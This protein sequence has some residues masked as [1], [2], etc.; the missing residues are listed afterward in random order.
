MTVQICSLPPEEAVV[1]RYIE[2]LWLPFHRELESTVNDHALATGVDLKA[3][4]LPFRLEQLEAD[5]HRA[6]VAVERDDSGPSDASLDLAA[7]GRLVGF[8]TTEVDEAPPV[9]DRPDRLVVG[10]LYVRDQYRGTGLAQKLMDRAVDR[11]QEAA[12]PELALDVDAD[13]ERAL[14]F[15]EKLGFDPA[16]HR[17]RAA[18]EDF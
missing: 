17:M 14:A 6:W 15:Y 4:E 5:S 13:N 12:C 7:D 8:I 9:F 3:E 16:R 2:E 11:A 18:V 1:R 10:D